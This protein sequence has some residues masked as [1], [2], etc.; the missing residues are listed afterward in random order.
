[1]TQQLTSLT[2]MPHE[3]IE[4]M[5]HLNS[6]KAWGELAI[7][8]GLLPQGMTIHQAMLIIQ[9]GREIGIAPLQSLRCM[10]FIKGRLV[11]SVQLQL[12]LARRQGVAIRELSEGDG[13]CRATLTRGSE[14]ITCTY[15]MQD[16]KKAGLVRADGAYDKYARQMLRWRAL[17]DALRLLAPDVVMGLLSPEEAGSIEPFTAA[18]IPE[19]ITMPKAIEA[20]SMEADVPPPS[21]PPPNPEGSLGSGLMNP[22]EA[23]I[24]HLQ[25]I[26]AIPHLSNSWNANAKERE[27]WTKEEQTRF[28]MAFDQRM[29]ELKEQKG[30]QKLV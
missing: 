9:T 21:P 7:K 26:Q 23:A 28:K 4:P 8:G 14:S 17:G 29:T 12:A 22:L 11:M 19:P 16:A 25:T 30:Q 13:V 6:L 18:D 10:N 20:P 24:A 5:S 2:T 27:S 3:E 15:T 1:M